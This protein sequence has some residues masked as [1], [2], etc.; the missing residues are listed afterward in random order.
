MKLVLMRSIL[1]LGLVSG[2]LLGGPALAA[3]DLPRVEDI[4]ER[5]AEAVG[6]KAANQ[7]VKTVVMKV[8]INTPE[9]H[10]HLTICY[11]GPDRYSKEVSI[12]G[13][14]STVVVVNG[15]TGWVTDSITGSRLLTGE[16]KAHVKN[17]ALGFAKTFSRVGNWRKD[18]KEV[19]MLG[20][21]RVEGKSAYKVQVNTV[22]GETWIDH[23]DKKS[24]LLLRRE[25]TVETPEGKVSTIELCSDYRTVDGITH[26]F[27]T[28]ILNGPTEVVVTI[29]HI[30]H[31]VDIP[32]ER[33]TLPTALRKVMERAAASPR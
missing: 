5:E 13:L 14:G 32:A 23:Y 1:G 10:N 20:E 16:E 11:A 21:E 29:T 17:E 9:T 6:G 19:K 31:N 33:F 8:K 27:T 25:T 22:T 4:L 26:A 30:E 12:E 15:D 18:Y 24:G 3:E 2:M 28:T 7:N